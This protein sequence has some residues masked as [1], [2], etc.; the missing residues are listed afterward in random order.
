MSFSLLQ[1]WTA[2][3][4]EGSADHCCEG[5]VTPTRAYKFL[6]SIKRE[7]ELAEARGG[8]VWSTLE[9]GRKFEVM[10]VL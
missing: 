7:Y 6:Y 2:G 5:I 10:A 4:P 8:K 9:N 1:T 3:Q